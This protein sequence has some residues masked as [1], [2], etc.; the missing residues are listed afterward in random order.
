M[1][2]YKEYL[3]DR[4]LS[5]RTIDTYC[6]SVDRLSAYLEGLQLEVS[7][8]KQTDILHFAGCGSL[9]S[10]PAIGINGFE[11]LLHLSCR[12]WGDRLQPDP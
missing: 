8:V 4:A 12:R 7:R 6:R 3:R 1:Q 11:K 2:E 9:P 5:A 10:F